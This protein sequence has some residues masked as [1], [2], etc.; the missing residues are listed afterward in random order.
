MTKLLLNS[1]FVCSAFV[2]AI[3]EF[4][5]TGTVQP[6]GPFAIAH[7]FILALLV[8]WWLRLDAEAGHSSGPLTKV[9]AIIFPPIA[10]PV[11]FFRSRGA[12]GGFVATAGMIGLV[13]LFG[14]S[15]V[16]GEYAAQLMR[17]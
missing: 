9:F 8:L 5:V 10:L 6:F 13:F 12:K 3:T 15:G 16:L 1:L 7:I 11:H 2:F 4:L 14:I 17:P